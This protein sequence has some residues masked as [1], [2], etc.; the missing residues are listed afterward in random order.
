MEPRWCAYS[1]RAGARRWLGS[2]SVATPALLLLSL[3]L[4]A[5]VRPVAGYTEVSGCSPGSWVNVSGFTSPSGLNGVYAPYIYNSASS[6]GL[7]YTLPYTSWPPYT[8]WPSGMTCN[9]NS[10]FSGN[11]FPD[12]AFIPR[13]RVS[14]CCV[15][16][17]S[18]RAYSFP[19]F[20]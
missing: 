19:R 2:H 14:Y 6:S 20:L 4:L 7:P 3:V 15:L 5:A 17:A 8:N 13:P 10:Y 16:T 11:V 18:R 9:L 12:G 1:G